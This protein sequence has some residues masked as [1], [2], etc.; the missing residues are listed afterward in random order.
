MPVGPQQT[1]VNF[2]P[3]R[4]TRLPRSGPLLLLRKGTADHRF[5][6]PDR[7][8]KFG[9]QRCICLAEIALTTSN[10]AACM[11]TFQGHRLRQ[12]GSPVTSNLWRQMLL[13]G[14]VSACTSA[15]ED[16]ARGVLRSGGGGWIVRARNE[17]MRPTQQQVFRRLCEK[18]RSGDR[19][20]ARQRRCLKSG[21]SF[22]PHPQGRKPLC[23]T[24]TALYTTAAHHTSA[25]RMLESI[26]ADDC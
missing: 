25:F 8:K 1:E 2:T 5:D 23:G 7:P 22:I 4:T 21:D 14:G 12:V 11:H 9:R 10:D 18:I 6:I 24:I 20:G 19:G 15:T 26:L 3:R 16:V 17:T 13:L